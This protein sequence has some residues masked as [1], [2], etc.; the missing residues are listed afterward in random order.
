MPR[1]L[2]RQAGALGL[3]GVSFPASAGG[4]GG[5][6]LAAVQAEAPRVEPGSR[7]RGS[8]HVAGGSRDDRVHLETAAARELN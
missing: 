6:L 1:E 2:H 4:G 8:L 7:W 3:P 5:D